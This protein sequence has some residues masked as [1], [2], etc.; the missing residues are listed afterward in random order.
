MYVSRNNC[1]SL[2]ISLLSAGVCA[3]VALGANCTTQA[4][5]SPVERNAIVDASRSMMLQV[6]NGNV[7]GLKTATLPS[8]AA[9]FAGIAASVQSLAPQVQQAF[10]TVDSVYDLDASGDPAGSANTQFFCGSPVVV[11]N[12]NNLPPGKYALAL[13]HATGV[14]EP[15]QVSLIL[16][17]SPEKRWLLAGFFAKPMI[18]AGHDGLWYW[19]SARKYAEA[20]GKWAAW[21]YYR[22]ANDLL[23]PMDNLTS[24]NLQKLQTELTGVK[25]DSLPSEKPMTLNANG[26]A[27]QV[28]A[29]DTTTQFGGLDLDVHYIPD[30]TQTAQLRDP[31]T[32][33]K[34]VVDIMNAL[35]AQHPELH[36][37]F[38]GMWVHAD[39]GD[40][41]LFALELPMEQIVPTGQP[42]ASPQPR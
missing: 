37:A 36:T 42:G 2:V 18:Q 5:M 16:A 27:F 13:L 9:D 19:V 35:V 7:D 4:Q 33:R 3:P 26:T 32:A 31:P 20:N 34:Q 21:F 1:L 29:I 8:V 12:F 22:L 25:P 30:P 38:H 23:D 6:Q 41:S 10:V 40:V 14:K 28:S 17:Q 39:Q 24:P 11:I 15:Q